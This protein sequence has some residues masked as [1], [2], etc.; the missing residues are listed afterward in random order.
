MQESEQR[1]PRIRRLGDQ[2]GAFYTPL[3]VAIAVAAWV[4]QR[5]GDAVSGGARRGHAVSAVDRH[6]GGDHRQHFAGGAARHHRERS[7]GAGAN[8]YLPHGDLRQDRHA[9]LWRTASDRPTGRPGLRS[10]RRADVGG[11]PGA[12]FETS[13][14]RSDSA[15]S[16]ER[17]TGARRSGRNSRAAGRRLARHRRRAACANHQPQQTG[18]D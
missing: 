2:L 4:D 18:R 11:Q 9:D 15:R 12:L 5:R 14:R 3:A 8:R 10:A 6:S 17:E 16:A 13:A 7:G 1:R